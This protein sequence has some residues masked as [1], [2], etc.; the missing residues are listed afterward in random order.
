MENEYFK[1]ALAS[2]VTGFAYGDAVRRM[3]DKGCSV[4]E[5][6]KNL[7]YPVSVETIEKVIK[8]YEAEKA[9]NVSKYEYVETRGEFGR[10]SFIRV[11]KD[12][13]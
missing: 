7:D 13:K 11:E 4:K 10:R 2:M 6:Q 1:E 12:K 8:E 5:I 9:R 3:H